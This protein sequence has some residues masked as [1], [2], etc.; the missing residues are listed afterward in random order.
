M[1]TQEQIEKRDGKLTASAISCLMTGDKER[2]LELWKLL[3]GDPSYVPPNFADNWPVQFGSATEA[4]NLEWFAKKHGTISRVGEVVVHQNG[5]FACT[6]DAWSDEYDCPIEC[7]T[8]GGFEKLS[9]VIERYQPQ[10]QFQAALTGA[11][12]VAFSVIEGGR[13]PKVEFI[14]RDQSYIAE[15]WKRGEDFMECV[16]TLCPPVI[17]DAVAEPTPMNALIEYDYSTNNAFVSAAADWLQN[18]LN[19]KKFE[20][21]ANTIKELVPKDA[22]KVIG[23]NI[24]VL[25]DRA[26]RL[27]IVE[28]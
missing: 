5:Y 6:L 16:K 13:E 21:A 25:R 12:K 8:V 4:I 3:V 24:V 17:L 22:A 20:E 9:V 2:I 19:A 28:K 27:K 14:P 7:K 18:K 15:L 26:S 1:L 23:G 11:D 10:I